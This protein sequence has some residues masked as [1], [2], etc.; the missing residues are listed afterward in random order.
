MNDWEV[1]VA[2]ELPLAQEEIEAYRSI[3]AGEAPA[4]GPLDRLLSLGLITPHPHK[5]E[6]YFAIDPRAAAHQLMIDAQADLARTV[7]RMGH[8]GA[9]ESLGRFY[10]PFRFY[11]G[12]GSE[13]LDREAMN[14]R[15]SAVSRAAKG[16]ILT[17]QPGEPADRD[18]EIHREGVARVCEALGR[19]VMVRTLYSSVARSHEP[20]RRYVEE[21]SAAGAEVRFHSGEFPRM[22]VIDGAHAFVDDFVV[23]RERDSGWHVG[24]PGAVMWA[25]NIY[26][27]H[28]GQGIHWADFYRSPASILTGRQEAI[29]K[30][31]AAGLSQPQVSTRLGHAERTIGK[32]LAAV[33]SAIGAT[34]LNEVMYWWGKVSRP[35]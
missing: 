29:L 18:P 3:A 9:I 27:T 25:R 2:D 12:P 15:I 7:E 21:I 10:D 22:M 4:D 31:L 19:R 20:T 17:A 23:G 11:G 6:E 16:E 30:Q 26:L 32:E 8:V 33:R 5:P 28:W 14:V 34:T 1:C 24:D 13:L 35:D